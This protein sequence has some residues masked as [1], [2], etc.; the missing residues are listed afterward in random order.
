MVTED[1]T[2]RHKRLNKRNILKWR[3]KERRV[4]KDSKRDKRLKNRQKT[5]QRNT[6]D[7]AKRQKTQRGTNDLT[8]S[9]KDSKG[10]ATST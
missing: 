6:K 4:T 8:Q 9:T 1:S 10:F 5:Q 7:S 2:K 3:D